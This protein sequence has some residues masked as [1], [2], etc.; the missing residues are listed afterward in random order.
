MVIDSVFA[1]TYFPDSD[2]LTET[3]SAG[4]SPI[5][6]CRIVGVVGHVRP[7]L[8]QDPST[9]TQIQAY[10]PLYQDPDKCAIEL[11]RR[12]DR[13]A[14]SVGRGDGDAIDQEGGLRRGRRPAGLRRSRD[15]GDYFGV[16]VVAAISNDP[17]RVVRLTGSYPLS[18]RD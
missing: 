15:A 11:S 6:P 4:F 17:S 7:W 10:L 5:G 3:L 16:D 9:Y 18:R 14:H 1:R 2:P 8:L 13:R 12:K